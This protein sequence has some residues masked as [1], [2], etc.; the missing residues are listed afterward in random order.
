[1]T[2]RDVSKLPYGPGTALW[3]YWTK[4]KGLAK[5]IGALHKWTTLHRLLKA[6]GVPSHMVDGLTTN[7]IDHVLPGYMKMVHK[8]EKREEEHVFDNGTCTRCGY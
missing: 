4:G 3:N 5:W 7:I 1:V 6:A 8:K 2:E